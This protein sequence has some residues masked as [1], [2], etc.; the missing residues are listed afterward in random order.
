MNS[1]TGLQASVIIPAYNAAHIL[2]RCL[3]ALER[4]TLPRTAY[5]II[6]VDDGS[7]EDRDLLLGEAG[8]DRC[9]LFLAAVRPPPEQPYG[10]PRAETR[11]SCV[12]LD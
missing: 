3:D 12:F 4:Q 5:E 8:L 2:P 9:L 7:E 10:S 1:D 6:V 11:G